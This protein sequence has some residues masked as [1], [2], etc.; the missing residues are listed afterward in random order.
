VWFT[1]RNA[2]ALGALN[3]VG[4]VIAQYPIPTAMADPTVI[5]SGPDGALYFC[6]TGAN[7]IGRAIEHRLRI[8]P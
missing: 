6:E 5:T 3:P 7:K 1:E 8:S 4:S 2:N